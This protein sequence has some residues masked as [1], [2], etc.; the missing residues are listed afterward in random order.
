MRIKIMGLILLSALLSGCASQKRFFKPEASPKIAIP[1]SNGASLKPKTVQIKKAQPKASVIYVPMV[2]ESSKI[3][4][5]KP[6]KKRAKTK[7]H[8]KAV[9]I[10]VENMPVNEF[11]KLVFGKVLKLSYFI[12]KNVENR[13]ESVTLKMTSAVSLEKLLS[14]VDAIL[15]RYNL[16]VSEKDGVYFINSGRQQQKKRLIRFFIG[17]NIPEGIKPDERIGMIIPLYYIRIIKYQWL[18]KRFALSATGMLTSISGSNSAIIIDSAQY[19]RAALKLIKL[20]DRPDFA[21]K[22]AVLIRMNYLLP[23]DFRNELKNI[24]P[25]QGIP[26]A[27]RIGT[28]GIILKP[29]PELSSIFVISP[30]KEWLKAV[31][32]WKNK[33]DTISALGDRPRMFVFYPKNRRAK[34][35]AKIFTGIGA[36]IVK[37]AAG[38]GKKKPLV[39]AQNF[40]GVKV[41]VDEDR[42]ALVVM[43]TPSTY[44]QIKNVLQRLDTLPKQVFVQVTIAEVTLTGQLQYGIEWYLKHSGKFTGELQTLG[45]LG[46]GTS[47]L[48]YSVIK[49]TGSFQ[50]AMNSFAQNNLIN[51]LSSPSL[52]VLDNKEASI[53]VG[54]EVPIITSETTAPSIQTSGSTSLLRSIEYRN[55]GVILH[56]K[57]TV[58]S[59]GILTMDINSEVSDAQTNNISPSISSPLILTR[60]INTSVALKS[61]STL[62]LGGLIK[63]TKSKTINEIPVL[64]NIPILGNL[65]KT[66]SK[67]NNRT[68]LIIEIT[69]YIISNIE[70]AATITRSY[71]SLMEL[72]KGKYGE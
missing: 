71:K 62:L 4:G 58:N 28:P 51:I 61:G 42:N 67:S 56:I 8:S 57:P 40:N 45:N 37:T 26:I 50:A 11:V 13:K 10:S 12:G 22:E 52:V 20:F 32:Y 15:S 69:P 41:V 27:S 53:N 48:T 49:N 14:M 35:L 9:K 44:Q 66:T 34:E 70:N 43:A 19:V 36:G 63:K 59:N 18:I 30:K 25:S 16:N 39:S 7:S 24:L 54:T 33:L 17:R 2:M 5:G 68:E 38:K 3:Y 29:M 64:G 1:S 72:F 21:K 31:L 55:T 47:G 46:I 23:E 65:F 6:I 60:D